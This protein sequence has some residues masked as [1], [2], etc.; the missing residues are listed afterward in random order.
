MF[1][2]INTL[3]DDGKKQ[4]YTNDTARNAAQADLLDMD[5]EYQKIQE[6]IK[7]IKRD[8]S[9]AQNNGEYWERIF[10]I[11]MSGEK[12]IIAELYQMM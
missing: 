10:N 6:T 4:K 3:S 8:M 5:L 9:D 11:R 2:V 1:D 7:K 12:R